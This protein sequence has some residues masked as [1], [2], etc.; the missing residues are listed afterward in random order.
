MPTAV[1]RL[2]GTLRTLF[3][4][5][6]LLLISGSIGVA[7]LTVQQN[8]HNF[9]SCVGTALGGTVLLMA[10]LAFGDNDTTMLKQLLR[11]AFKAAIFAVGAVALL[12]FIT[13]PWVSMLYSQDPEVLELARTAICFYAISMP[14]YGLVQVI[15]NFC[16]ATK[17]VTLSM[18]ICVLDNFLLIVVPAFVLPNI[19]GINGV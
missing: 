8:S 15:Q 16:Q 5:Y 7:A 2:C 10:N 19:F 3:L 17:K 4:N 9:F 11:L 6:Q 18:I 1:G 13:A 14:I 12:L